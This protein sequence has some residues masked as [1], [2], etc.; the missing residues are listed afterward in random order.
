MFFP[1]FVIKWPFQFQ[2]VVVILE[3]YQ[4]EKTS[5]GKDTTN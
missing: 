2:S 1:S 4:K 3:K 5:S